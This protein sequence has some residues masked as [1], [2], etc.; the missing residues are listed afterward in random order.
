MN[1]H[2]IVHPFKLIWIVMQ[3]RKKPTETEITDCGFRHLGWA[4][5]LLSNFKYLEQNKKT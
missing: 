5:E 2:M 3:G 1:Q 4:I